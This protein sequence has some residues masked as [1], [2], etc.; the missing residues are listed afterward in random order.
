M[1]TIV[2]KHEGILSAPHST[3]VGLD[4]RAVGVF[5]IEDNLSNLMITIDQITKKV[6]PK[7]GSYT[8][9]Y[10]LSPGRR[11]ALDTGVR[12]EFPDN[13]YGEIWP[14]SGL[15]FKSG[16]DV[17]AGLIDPGYRD[18]IKVIL[19]NHSR[20]DFMIEDQARIAQ[21]VL[22]ERNFN[23]VLEPVGVSDSTD[24]GTKGFGSSGTK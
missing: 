5:A 9:P 11:V 24:R 6:F 7:V 3:D 2:I 10:I 21:L 20:M 18:T 22:K 14:R 19:I 1:N 13:V 12:C 15:A 17:L 8:L 23:I 16:I 4:L